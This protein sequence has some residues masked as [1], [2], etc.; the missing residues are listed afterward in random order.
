MPAAV[1]WALAFLFS[2]Q[3]F[4]DF[5]GYSSIAMG[6]AYLLGFKLPVNFN[7]PYIASSFRNFWTRWHMTLS[8]W[9]RDYLY[10][11]MG[12]NRGSLFRN[13]LTLMATMALAGLWHGAA[14]TFLIWGCLHGLALTVERVLG[15]HQVDHKRSLFLKIGWFLAV[16]AVVLVGWVFFR[17]ESVSQAFEYLRN[18][19]SGHW[20]WEYLLPIAPA[21][22][23]TLPV[24]LLHLRG[25][26]IEGGWLKAAGPREK[27]VLAAVML[28]LILTLYGKNN[29]FIYFQF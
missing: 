23:F 9:I 20:G 3:I 22:L 15:F 25:F 27:A 12:G 14:F 4:A 26:L 28:Y 13:F 6:A 18:M 8:R 21:F 17:A 7:R 19:A 29:A 5:F 1:P 11:P 16:Q 24:I 10:I 2:C